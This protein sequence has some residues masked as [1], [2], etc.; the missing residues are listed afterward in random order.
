[1][2][3]VSHGAALSLY[4]SLLCKKVCYLVD[5]LTFY[6][7]SQINKSYKIQQY[8]TDLLVLLYALFLGEG[9]CSNCF[10]LFKCKCLLYIQRSSF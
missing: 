3:G 4:M 10:L 8:Y 2:V 9:C 5:W 6:V 1:M 7:I